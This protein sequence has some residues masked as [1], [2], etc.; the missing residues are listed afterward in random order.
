MTAWRLE[1]KDELLHVAELSVG[2]VEDGLK[3]RSRWVLLWWMDLDT[4]HG[5]K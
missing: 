4:L 1:E 3:K 5:S 2:G